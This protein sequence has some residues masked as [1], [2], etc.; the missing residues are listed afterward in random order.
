MAMKTDPR[1]PPEGVETFRARSYP[2]SPLSDLPPGRMPPADDEDPAEATFSPLSVDAPAGCPHGAPARPRRPSQL[3]ARSTSGASLYE[4]IGRTIGVR[5]LVRRFFDLMET[6][7]EAQPCRM[8]YPPDLEESRQK[9]FEFMNGWLGGPKLYL[10]RRGAPK[11]RRRH[12]LMTIGPAQ[13]D[14]WLLCFRRAAMETISDAGAIDLL[15]PQ[16]ESIAH[17][18][19]NRD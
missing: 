18:L 10:K 3:N 19:Q 12:F 16:V 7:P 11:L 9:F 8:I 6:L 1:L 5:R 15:M 13:V 14:A 17:Y 4:R 2:L